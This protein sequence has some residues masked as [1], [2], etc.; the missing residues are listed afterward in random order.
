MKVPRRG[1][2]NRGAVDG[3]GAL[4]LWRRSLWQSLT[5]YWRG[6]ASTRGRAGDQNA[7]QPAEI[8]AI[9]EEVLT[10]ATATSIRPEQA[11]TAMTTAIDINQ[12]FYRTRNAHHCSWR[13]RGDLCRTLYRAG[14]CA[15]A[16]S[17]TPVDVSADQFD[18]QRNPSRV[19]P[20][21]GWRCHYGWRLLHLQ[22]VVS[23][24]PAG[25]GCGRDRATAR[26]D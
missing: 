13:Y 3:S 11:R 19:A 26:E 15:M 16:T 1:I 21:L 6:V 10:R 14:R 25:A 22:I 4:P 8:E 5:R 17:C 18:H 24:L 23:A 2:R 20:S 12:Y 9:L 7:K